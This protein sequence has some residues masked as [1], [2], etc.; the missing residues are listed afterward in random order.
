MAKYTI[1]RSAKWK[2]FLLLLYFSINSN[3]SCDVVKIY[4]YLLEIWYIQ[5]LKQGIFLQETS[6]FSHYSK[7]IQ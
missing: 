5:L 3:G 1:P 4:F 2:G 7:G 6:E